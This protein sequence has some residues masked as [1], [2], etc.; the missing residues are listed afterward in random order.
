[1]T[2][3][4]GVDPGRLRVALVHDWLNGYRGGE[5]VLREFAELFPQADVYT[6]FYV[7]GTTHP[8]IERLPIHASWM[9]QLPGVRAR[10]R[11]LLPLFPAWADGLQLGDY[12]L[13]VSS[14]HCVAKGARA[15]VAGRHLCYCHTPMRYV[16][17]RFDD[18]FGHLPQ[19]LRQAVA[20]Q[21][22]RLRRWDRASADRVDLYLA[23]S[24]FV[25]ERI[26]RFYGPRA[27][28]VSVLSPP[29]DLAAMGPLLEAVRDDRYLVVSALV[30]YKRIDVA[31]AACAAGQRR[32]TVAGDG[33]QRGA[34]SALAARTRGADVRFL[35]HVS[36]A[37]LPRLYRSHRALLFPGVED[38]GI[39]PVEAMACGLPVIAR[40]EGGVLDSLDEECGLLYAGSGSAELLAAIERFEALSA[41]FDAARLR[42][43]AERFD[44]PH[45][46]A[47]LLEHVSRLFD[48]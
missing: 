8:S 30:P 46:R 33:P 35:G 38:F 13:V 6:L 14:S 39:T 4:I 28:P 15:G 29:V 23:N 12:D 10:Y 22:E 1:L 19:P 45:F 34:L 9:N 40:A 41:Q 21:A 24:H 7:A 42:R 5:K 17:D 27:R 43:R 18:Y 44:R 26:E 36:D 2:E 20:W 37:E 47:A 48:L 16:W 25:R 31:I 3:Q 32:L 11:W